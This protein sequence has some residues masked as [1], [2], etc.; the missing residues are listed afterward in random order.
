MRI[1][2]Q[3]HM[4]YNEGEQNSGVSRAN[5]KILT[6]IVKNENHTF[7]IFKRDATI[8]SEEITGR[9]NVMVAP[10]WNKNRIY[11]L[12]GRELDQVTSKIDFWFSL[13]GKVPIL[14]SVKSGSIIYDLFCLHYP[15]YF[16]D[17]TRKIS[18][19]HYKNIAKNADVIACIS[20][21]V[22]NDFCTNYNVGEEKVFTIPLS[23]GQKFDRVEITST[24]REFLTDFGIDKDAPYLFTI[25]TL[26]PRKNIVR[27]LEAFRL[28]I[29]IEQYS[30]FQLVVVGARGWKENAIFEKINTLELNNSVKFLGFIQDDQ[31][32]KLFAH[33]RA[34][35]VA[36]LDEGF[37]MPLLEAFHYGSPVAS[38]NKGSLRE[39]GDKLPEYFDP[40]NVEQM[41][42]AIIKVCNVADRDTLVNKGFERARLF[43]WEDA[44]NII[45][46]KIERACRLS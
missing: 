9:S 43:N 29:D 32:P 16:T 18:L 11:N 36:S 6:E 39:V 20:D 21:T 4:I 3:A 15:E 10:C 19:A 28:L 44:A 7:T 34:T 38:S 13:G 30:D 27:L 24:D 26:E 8:L 14:G 37:G 22:K 17:M 35:I 46:E 41:L 2:L 12:V 31:I 45:V 25:S 33:A 42:T 23:I 40:T 5:L 1:G